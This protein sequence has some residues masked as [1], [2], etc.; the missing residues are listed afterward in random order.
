[1]TALMADILMEIGKMAPVFGILIVIIIYF[2]KKENKHVKEIN[3]ER[4]SY[5]GRIDSLNSEV[6]NNEKQN[7]EMIGKLADALDKL[8]ESTGD[9]HKDLNELKHNLNLKLEE[10]KNKFK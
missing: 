9:I 2:F 1:M 4:S 10:L 3:D 6:R 7:I 5:R 8:S